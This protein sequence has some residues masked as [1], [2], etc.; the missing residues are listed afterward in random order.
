MNLAESLSAFFSQNAKKTENVKIAASHRFIDDETNEAALWEIK[1]ITAARNAQLR[2]E[3]VRAAR[4]GQAEFDAEQY[5]SKLCAEC[6][7][8]PNLN[9]AALQQSYG[10]MGAADLIG[11]MLTPAEFEEY[12]S[13]VLEQNGFKTDAQ[14]VDEAKN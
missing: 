1:T 14:M 13:R 11:A 6:T 12:A 9:D 4:A 5:L 2:R 8:Y 7:V 10:V 3:S